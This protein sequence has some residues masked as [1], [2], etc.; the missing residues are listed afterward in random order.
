[1]GAAAK[2]HEPARSM[3]ASSPDTTLDA[4]RREIDLIDDQILDL[5]TRRFAATGR[6][7]ATKASDGSIA[8]SPFRPAREAAMLRRL[9]A[10]AGDKLPPETLVRLWRVI[11]SASTQSQASVTVHVAEALGQDLAMRLLIAQHFCGMA[12]EVHRAPSEVLAA[13]R[14]RQGDLGLIAPASDWAAGFSPD[15]PGSPRVIGSLPV[16]AGGG[17]PK[18]LVFG[19]A[20]AQESG[21]DETL[22]ISP[23]V[24]GNVPS[25]LWQA[26]AGPFALISL[27]GFLRRDDPSLRDVLAR[28]P[29]AAVAGCYPRPIKVLT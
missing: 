17:R 20:P 16:T 21:D 4:I 7:K 26:E 8:A 14:T 29:G 15:E 1:M 25:A 23:K 11:L 2:P 3:T 9:I 6:V 19:H 13:L 12:V 10:K 18:L 5:L 24:L 28:A 27:P 22:V